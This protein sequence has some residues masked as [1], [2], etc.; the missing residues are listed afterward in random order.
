MRSVNS[1]IQKYSLFGVHKIYTEKGFKHASG[2]CID[3]RAKRRLIRVLKG[4]KRYLDEEG[5]CKDFWTRKWKRWRIERHQK[6]VKRNCILSGQ[7]IMAEQVES[8]SGQ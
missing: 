4:G 8:M 7:I 6:D 3:S 2:V 1:V 5:S